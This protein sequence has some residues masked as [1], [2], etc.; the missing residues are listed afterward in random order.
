MAEDQQNGNA[1]RK[2]SRLE[3][4]LDHDSFAL[5]IG[6]EIA[7]ADCALAMCHQA[8]RYFEQQLR[9]QAAVGFA[10]AVGNARRTQA[11]IEQATRSVR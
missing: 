9:Q 11:L 8:V 3:L 5:H 1:A 10:Q 6:G 4:T 2:V 7:N